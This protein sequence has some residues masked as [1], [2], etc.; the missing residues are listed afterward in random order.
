MVVSFSTTFSHKFLDIHRHRL[1]LFGGKLLSKAGHLRRC[2]F[3]DR[4]YDLIHTVG[5]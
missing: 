5:M 4:D 3:L 2:S 1:Y